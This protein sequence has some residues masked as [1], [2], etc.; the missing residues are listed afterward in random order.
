L[1]VKL[2]SKARVTFRDPAV[3]VEVPIG[4][5][6]LEAALSAG[7]IEA[8]PC[9]GHCACGGCHV[10]IEVGGQHLSC[11]SELEEDQLDRAFDVRPSSRLACQ[12]RIIAGGDIAVR[13][14]KG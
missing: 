10:R 4:I 2:G 9:G 11:A 12:A 14:V 5:T 13:I 8:G 7:A 3:E 6:L 1:T